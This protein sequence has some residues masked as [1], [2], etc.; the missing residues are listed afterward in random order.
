M[1]FSVCPTAVVAAPVESVWELLADPASYD[2]WWDARTVRIAP[3]GMAAPGQ[4]V[5]ATTSGFG[6]TWDVTLRV[7]AV[8]PARHQLHLR[9]ALPLGVAL[10]ATSCRVAFG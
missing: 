9:I 3:E 10:D 4:V 8:D 6:K 2:V 5:Y 1:G 7:A